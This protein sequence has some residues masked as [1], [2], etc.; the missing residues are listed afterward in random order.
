MK[1]L[2]SILLAALVMVS[3]AAVIASPGAPPSNAKPSEQR[4]KARY[5]YLEAARQQAEGRM[6]EAYEYFK[7]AYLTDPSYEEAAS[8]YGTNRLMVQTDSMQSSRELL[9]SLSMM[10]PYVDAYPADV[11]E[12]RSYAYVAG[13]L[14]SISETIRVYERLDSLR[15]KETLLLLQLADAYMSDNQQEKALQTLDRFEKAEGASPQLSLKKMSFML[16]KGD[17]LAAVKEADAL[18]ATNPR[19]PSYLILKGNLYEVIGNNDSTLSCYLRAEALDPEKGDAK[20]ALA[21]FY[22]N[23]GDSTAYDTKVYEALLSEDFGIDEKLGMLSEYLQTLLDDSSD[24]SRG[25]H[26]FSVLREQFPHEAQVLD[27]AARYS[28]AK[29]DFKDAEEQIGYAIDQNPTNLEYWGQ[30]M[31]YQL[32]DSRPEDAVATYKRAVSHI[33]APPGLTLLYANAA[34]LAKDFEEAENAYAILIHAENPTLPL[35]DPVTDNALRTSLSYEG[36]ARLSSLYNMLGDMY[37]ASGDLDKTYKA[38]DNSL[39]FLSSNPLTLNNY[40]YFMAENGGDLDRALEMSRT[41]VDQD[42]ENETYL[43]TLA[44]ILFKKRDY[45]EALEYQQKAISLAEAAGDSEAA[46]FYHHLGDILFMNNQPEEALANWKKALEL[47]PDNELLK[48]KVDHK[49]FFYK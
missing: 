2:H 40:A 15:P 47:E 37:Y 1:R 5:Y 44:W 43:D 6:P 49:T 42:P 9:K 14:D 48:K 12:A 3:A 10:R 26:L 18:I 16:A 27:L 22:K 35:T 13:R 30:L 38:Y 41:A 32:A 45:K 4:Q 39:F 21:N 7:K 20:I 36:L 34:S 24:T 11:N 23:T 29:G 28:A 19:E 31:R 17:T 46:E 25:D 8:A 33:D